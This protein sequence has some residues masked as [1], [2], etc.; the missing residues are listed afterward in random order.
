MH[1]LCDYLTNKVTTMCMF[2]PFFFFSK[3]VRTYDPRSYLP[4]TILRR[5]LILTTLGGPAFVFKISST[6]I[7]QNLK[8]GARDE[9]SY[10]SLITYL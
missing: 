10:H 2:S 7:S 8:D 9:L 3:N 5:I 4:P 6:S 1:D